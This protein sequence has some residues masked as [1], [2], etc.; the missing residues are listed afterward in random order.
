MATVPAPVRSRFSHRHCSNSM[1]GMGQRSEASLRLPANCDNI[2]VS[3]SAHRRQM[4]WLGARRTGWAE[5]AAR[6]AMEA[7]ATSPGVAP[8]PNRPRW[9]AHQALPTP[10]GPTEAWK[11][12][13]SVS[14]PRATAPR[15]L[16]PPRRTPRPAPGPAAAAAA[17]RAGSRPTLARPGAT[18]R[19]ASRRRGRP[20]R[21]P[22]PPREWQPM[23]RSCHTASGSGG[24]KEA[25][26]CP[27]RQRARHPTPRRAPAANSAT[28]DALGERA[29]HPAP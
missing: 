19:A 23:C 15:W 1:R 4:V 8:P 20:P 21:G 13:R 17:P 2:F 27:P 10:T 16:R 18:R 11:H 14:L 26:R 5:G 29:R 6:E 25:Q 24:R 22:P 9:L 7:P 3:H 12:P 28:G